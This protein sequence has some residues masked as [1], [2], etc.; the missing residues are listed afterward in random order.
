[1]K[2]VEAAFNQERVLVRAF[3]VDM[4]LWRTFVSS[5]PVSAVVGVAAAGGAELRRQSLSAGEL[6][7][8]AA[9]EQTT[10]EA[11]GAA[12]VDTPFKQ[13]KIFS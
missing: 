1:M 10:V 6:T 3:S 13:I 7:R 11:R 2:P 9:A 5:S 12:V 4:N 8:G